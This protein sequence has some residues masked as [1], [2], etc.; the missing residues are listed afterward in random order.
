MELVAEDELH[1]VGRFVQRLPIIDHIFS[2]ADP[3]IDSVFIETTIPY[4]SGKARP[5]NILVQ[6]VFDLD[7]DST[8]IL[9]NDYPERTEDI[10]ATAKK[11]SKDKFLDRGS[12]AKY[13]FIRFRVVRVLP[14]FGIEQIY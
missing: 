9:T 1:I 6:R 11:Y 10:L 12:N 2:S 13:Y 5:S 14:E 7:K 3:N 4:I 8:I